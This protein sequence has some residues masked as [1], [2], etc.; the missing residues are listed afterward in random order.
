MKP[1]PNTEVA[2]YLKEI[3][4]WREI[5]ELAV[6]SA[7]EM[8]GVKDTEKKELLV[9]QNC[10]TSIECLVGFLT[11]LPQAHDQA[12]LLSQLLRSLGAAFVAGKY[13]S[14]SPVAQKLKAKWAAHARSGKRM[15]ETDEII[16]KHA[17]ALFDLN[18]KRVGNRK[19]TST[20]IVSKVNDERRQL[21]MKETTAD[22]IRRRLGKLVQLGK[23]AD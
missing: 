20:N 22:A 16:R 2:F 12:Y 18:P 7:F 14:E 10:V 4:N 23:L 5:F 1:Q 15:D 21:G 19:G 13:D 11:D 6:T 17:Q 9:A 3:T 8:E